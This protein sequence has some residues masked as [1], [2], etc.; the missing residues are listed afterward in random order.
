MSQ[1][2]PTA[3]PMRA[4]G[5]G[6]LRRGWLL[7]LPGLPQWWRGERS[8]G[9]VLLGW[10]SSAAAVAGFAWGSVVG[11]MLL[12][13]AFLVHCASVADEVG[14]SAFPGFGAWAP[15]YSAVVGL[16]AVGYLPGL[17]VALHL[18][19]PAWTDEGGY[20]VNRRAYERQ[21]PRPG[22]WVWLDRRPAGPSS[23]G[24]ARV[25]AVAGQVVSWSR[26]ELFVEGRHPAFDPGQLSLPPRTQGRFEVPERALLVVCE[27]SLPAVGALSPEMPSPPG[28][29][30]IP[31]EWVVGQ[32]W[33]RSYP[34]W[35][36]HWLGARGGGIW[37]RFVLTDR[38]SGTEPSSG[39][40]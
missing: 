8:R 15:W 17:V 38:G 22:E 11:A 23:G 36:R 1:T 24:M 28:L 12:A 25:V 34:I 39:L 16:G 19:H 3:P 37:K 26:G 10:Y 29:E 20:L 32:A 18:A 9:L 33:A 30:L 21:S 5:D 35:Q 31:A 13:V 4:A 27:G 7:V 40:T 14:Q 2:G 6:M